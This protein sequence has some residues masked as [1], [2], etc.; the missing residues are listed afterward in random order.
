[1]PLHPLVGH[2]S[3]RRRLADQAGRDT[4]PASMLLAGPAGVGKQRLALW[5]AQLLLCETAVRDAR[6]E[7]CG[8]CTSCRYA[9]DAAHP[10]LIWVFPRPRLRDASDID[11][12]DAA[13]EIAESARERVEEGLYARPDGSSAI[14]VYDARVLVNRAAKKPAL[15]SR[16][17]FVIGD[18]ERMVPQA[19]SAEAAN[20]VL[21][22]LEE[23]SPGTTIILTSSE[24]GA[25]LPTIRSRVVTIRVPAL[26][27]AA[28]RE[29][30]ALPV[31]E[32]VAK[33]ASAELAA[34]GSPGALAALAD[35]K[36]GAGSG[37]GATASA[38]FEAARGGERMLFRAA[39]LQG[40]TGARGGFSDA[41][42]ALTALLHR[43][44]AAATA[45]G[46]DHAARN[47]ARAV[48][49]VEEAKRE[50]E[51][52]AAPQLVAWTL[53]RRISPLLAA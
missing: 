1:M 14:F 9:L 32:A 30:L 8:T 28:M 29:F 12:D 49:C 5:L 2:E 22:M 38:L 52:N 35:A 46:D 53:L 3:L 13:S 20:A 26:P 37:A 41:L 31:A 6:A 10:D 25:L 43:E 16:K 51:Q 42:D 40:S 36:A 7:P 45:R 33:R 27:Q 24:P 11:V 44:V 50:A 34:A 21:K 19:S 18:A 4:L 15:G 47:A 23:P 39:Y 48:V 17:V